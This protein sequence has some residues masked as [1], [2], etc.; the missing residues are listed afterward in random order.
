[1]DVRLRQSY[2]VPV[3]LA[4]CLLA[5]LVAPRACS[6]WRVTAA[7]WLTPT[8]EARTPDDG[9]ASLVEELASLREE[10]RRL[11][12]RT[13]AL[14]VGSLGELVDW[15]V[16]EPEGA[17]HG[18][19]AHLVPC[20]VL[21][22]TTSTLRRSFLVDRGREDGVRTGLAVTTGNSLVGVVR[23]VA[24]GAAEV[25]RV[26]DPQFPGL[27]ARIDRESPPAA[28][29]VPAGVDAESAEA[30]AFRVAA[31]ERPLGVARGAGDGRLVVSYLAA[32]DAVVGDLVLT[33]PGAHPIPEGLVLGRVE[34]FHDDDRDG[35]WE[36]EVVPLRALD[37]LGA[38]FVVVR[39][40]LPAELR[41]R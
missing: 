40:E 15:E 31:P 17:D 8:A 3:L 24:P 26:D 39:P 32:D 33:G 22:R 37:R 35:D 7:S 16:V 28:V 4:A 23:T 9:S 11:R 1:M 21:H 13:A 5:A 36:A 10:N 14:P 34:R 38:L 25:L 18:L 2:R 27:P 12:E 41:A 20:R 30:A 29:H 6:E 19:G